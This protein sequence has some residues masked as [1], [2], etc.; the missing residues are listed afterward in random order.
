MGNCAKFIGKVKLTSQ[1]Q[2]TLPLESRKEL[3]ID[4]NSDVYWYEYNGC[5]V[6]VKDLIEEKKIEEKMKRKS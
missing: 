3:K 5:L 4:D 6:L 2:I 1:G